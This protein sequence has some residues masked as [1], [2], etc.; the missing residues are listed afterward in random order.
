MT[1][2]L[3]T[4]HMS[5]HK[6]TR[7]VY[8]QIY[9]GLLSLKTHT[10][11]LGE[12]YKVLH[13]THCRCLCNTLKN[14]EACNYAMPPRSLSPSEPNNGRGCSLMRR[15][16]GRQFPGDICGESLGMPPPPHPTPPTPSAPH[17]SPLHPPSL[18][19]AVVRAL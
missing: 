15:D 17:T 19:T 7:T 6:Y 4:A 9:R 5:R 14:A 1:N 8:N 3:Q 18:T 11:T 10:I 2:R 12:M 13:Y 16:I